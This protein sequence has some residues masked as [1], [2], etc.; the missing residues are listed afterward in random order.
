MGRTTS[1]ALVALLGAAGFLSGEPVAFRLLGGQTV[2]VPVRVNGEGPFDFVL[3]TGTTTTM[4]EPALAAALSLQPEDRAKLVHSGGSRIVA[5]SRS[6]SLALGPARAEGLSLL[7]ANLDGPRRAGATIQGVLGQNFLSRFNYTLD[8][9]RRQIVLADADSFSRNTI[10]LPLEHDQGRALVAVEPGG[11]SRARLRLALDSGAGRLVLF[12]DPSPS[13]HLN[14]ERSAAP[15]IL[16][17]GQGRRVVRSGWL[18]ALRL[19]DEVLRDIPVA[20][21][22]R[23]EADAS[24]VEQ[25]LLPTLLFRAVY[26]NNRQGFVVLTR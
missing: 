7:V 1:V 22:T 13:A 25:G 5:R 19:G 20:V 4:V 16:A 21:L 18:K 9:E 11:G 14:V 2:V 17:S 8:Y 3:D 26:F 23:T 24:R 10:R 12:E 6:R 15:L